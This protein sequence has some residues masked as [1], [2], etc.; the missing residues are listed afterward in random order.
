M[1]DEMEEIPIAGGT[2]SS[3]S[4][5]EDADDT[6]PLADSSSE[7]P[8][9][10]HVLNETS[11]LSIAF[12]TV[13]NL[14]ELLFSNDE[15]AVGE[16]K[17]SNSDSRGIRSTMDATTMSSLGENLYTPATTDATTMSNLDE[18]ISTTTSV[19][20][21]TTESSGSNSGNSSSSIHMSFARDNGTPLSAATVTR[22]TSTGTTLART[23]TLLTP[24]RYRSSFATTALNRRT[25]SNISTDSGLRLPQPPLFVESETR[26]G[27]GL[28]NATRQGLAQSSPAPR[29][30]SDDNAPSPLSSLR[31]TATTMASPGLNH[32]SA[33]SSTIARPQL[34]QLNQ[35][36]DNDISYHESLT[37]LASAYLVEPTLQEPANSTT[38]TII[39]LSPPHRPCLPHRSWCSPYLQNGPNRWVKELELGWE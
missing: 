2:D 8:N 11:E 21:T 22:N 20:R 1:A 7:T 16:K 30:A 17:A 9:A 15:A 23:S 6:L 32:A 39:Q 38:T 12:P 27:N 25:S 34:P 29:R 36:V 3:M 5:E 33:V 18:N 13:N 35:S 31:W 37:V 19:T 24:V 10:L 28:L 4:S 26:V 14:M